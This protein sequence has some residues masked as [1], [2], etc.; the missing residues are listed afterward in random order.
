MI[1]LLEKIIFKNFKCFEEYEVDFS[2]FNV[3]VGKNN[4]G[5]STVIDGIKIISNV[6]RYGSYRP[7]TSIT[8]PNDKKSTIDVCVLDSR[9]IPFSIIN[10]RYNYINEDSI[11]VAKFGNKKEIKI[12]FPKNDNNPYAVF[13]LN[14]KIIYNPI[15][16]RT[17]FPFSIGIVPNVG[18]FEEFEEIGDKKY[19]RSIIM[20]HLMP[21]H[22]RNIWNYYDDDFEEF[23]KLLESTWPSYT[24]EHPEYDFES[25]KLNMFFREENITREIFWSGHG[26][27][28]WLQLLT[29]LVKLGKKDTLVLDEPDV[30]LHS[31]L[32]KKLIHLCKERS[33][34]V[35]IATHAV[36]I[37]E[38]CNPEDIIPIDNK[39]K[40]SERLSS[41][42][43]VQV[44]VTQMGS[45]QNLKL[46]H[47][48]KGKTCLFIEGQ[49]F[50]YLKRI[51]EILNEDTIINENGFSINPLDG[52]ANWERL[53]DINWMFLTSLGETI[54]CYVILDRDY[55]P[56]NSIKEIEETLQSR[57]VRVHIWEKKEIENYAINFLVIY[58]LFVKKYKDRYPTIKEIPI[59]FE[60]FEEKL[61]QIIEEFKYYIMGQLTGDEIKLRSVKLNDVSSI[62]EK[63]T[64][65]FEIRW[66]D[67]K[68]KIDMTPGKDF[69]A[70]LNKWLSEKYHLSM[71][72]TAVLSSMKP[73]EIDPEVSNVIK[74]FVSLV[75]S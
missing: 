56:E 41:I 43:D 37:I 52:S 39:L 63:R 32:Q 66:K 23:K 25:N 74:E 67:I 75:K 3:I 46:V 9:D 34:Q 22:F 48:L 30:Y 45:Y 24:I 72:A 73:N 1:I 10:L 65:D 62:V 44:C 13:S 35:I 60:E 59:S 51:S 19:V 64:S 71:S 26:L 61:L 7:F 54:K 18:L 2:N 17:N 11:I 20:T 58:R 31:D 69:F 27:Q 33:N 57:D 15:I 42:S 70:A 14:K 40:R 4:S 49:D 16:I 6:M 8:D 53:K 68:Y 36:D 38:E 5:K 55:R 47:F 50:R 28:I 29:Y 12:V 21:R